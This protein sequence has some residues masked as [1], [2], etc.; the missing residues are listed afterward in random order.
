MGTKRFPIKSALL[1]TGVW[2]NTTEGSKAKVDNV[3]FFIK[4]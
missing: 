1:I 3:I 2:A 4:Y